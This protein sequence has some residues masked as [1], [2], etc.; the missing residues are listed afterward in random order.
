MKLGEKVSFN[1]CYKKSGES[2]DE[3]NLT[4][5]Q[6]KELDENDCIV[7]NRLSE[8]AFEKTIEGIVCGKRRRAYKSTFEHG[9]NRFN[10]E[11][12]E[13]IFAITKT[14]CIDIYLIASNLTGFYLVPSKWLERVGEPN[15]N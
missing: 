8:H 13:W 10:P 4:E 5:D 7:L 12:D 9:A 11:C 15:G 14:E 1:R 3:N 6:Q 2:I